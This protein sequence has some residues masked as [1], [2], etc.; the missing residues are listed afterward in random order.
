V[1]GHD[2]ALLYE[3]GPASC[4]PAQPRTLVVE[5]FCDKPE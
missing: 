1:N 4:R 5:I 2:Q 3:A